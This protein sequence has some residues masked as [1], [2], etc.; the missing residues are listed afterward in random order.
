MKFF[1]W[2]RYY[3]DHEEQEQRL[4]IPYQEIEP[5]KLHPESWNK[6]P[7]ARRLHPET[8]II[9][10]WPNPFIMH[11]LVIEVNLIKKG[12][13]IAKLFNQLGIDSSSSAKDFTEQLR[14]DVP[15]HIYQVPAL[16]SPDVVV[17]RIRDHSKAQEQAKKL[18]CS[19]LSVADLKNPSTLS[20]A[21]F[22]SRLTEQYLTFHEDWREH[23][24]PLG[25]LFVASGLL[26][27]ISRFKD[28]AA[29]ISNVDTLP[30]EVSSMRQ[31]SHSLFS[32]I[33]EIILGS[34]LWPLFPADATIK[35]DF[36]KDIVKRMQSALDGTFHGY[37]I[38]SI[39]S[40]TCSRDGLP[41]SRA[42]SEITNDTARR[43]VGR[44]FEKKWVETSFCESYEDD[45]ETPSV[46]V[47]A[48]NGIMSFYMHNMDLDLENFVL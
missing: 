31:H 17:L 25:D 39:S 47:N 11:V 48:C 2:E 45:D 18:C 5:R 30:P 3:E 40:S 4:D 8:P 24:P 28:F 12:S 23:L 22:F 42:L 7:R 41:S 1:D 46:F 32:T 38:S 13:F 10:P 44:T 33:L 21:L 19:K 27:R 29:G 35:R 37:T 36:V 14:F 16:A 15:R 26:L 34:Y 43:E 6:N 9:D 20:A